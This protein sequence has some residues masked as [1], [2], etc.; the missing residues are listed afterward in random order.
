[1]MVAQIAPDRHSTEPSA[2]VALARPPFDWDAYWA[3]VDPDGQEPAP[4]VPDY[5]EE[6]AEM[7]RE[8]FPWNR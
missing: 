8:F 1:M 2:V 6:Q 4:V 3:D 7:D 5:D